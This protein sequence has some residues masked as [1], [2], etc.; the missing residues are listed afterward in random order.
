[1]RKTDQELEQILRDSFYMSFPKDKN[2]SWVKECI[3]F[4]FN[5][6]KEKKVLE[7]DVFMAKLDPIDDNIFWEVYK[8]NKIMVEIDK[9][10][11]KKSYIISYSRY[12][13]ML[14]FS[15]S[16]DK[17]LTVTVN[18]KIPNIENLDERDFIFFS[19]LDR[20]LK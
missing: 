20:E 6:N 11:G 10:T 18:Y 1:M 4:H 7:L 15:A 16:L 8:G 5:L 13:P 3:S 2:P 19:N 17:S 12:T 14:V 9:L